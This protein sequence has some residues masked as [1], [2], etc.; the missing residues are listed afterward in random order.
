MAKK[1]LYSPRWSHPRE[2]QP[3]IKDE[4]KMFYIVASPICDQQR[5]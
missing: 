5:D 1:K 3:S 4:N 2:I